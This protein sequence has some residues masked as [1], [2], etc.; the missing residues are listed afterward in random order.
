MEKD[1]H[2]HNFEEA[3]VV[4]DVKCWITILVFFL[5]SVSTFRG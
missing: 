3:M 5:L 2:G 1:M 4:A